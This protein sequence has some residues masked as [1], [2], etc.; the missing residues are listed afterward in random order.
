MKI[1]GGGETAE[2]QPAGK[3]AEAAVPQAGD[4]TD[5]ATDRRENRPPDTRFADVAGLDE[6]KEAV[7][8]RVILPHRYP[9]VYKRFDKKPGGGVLL[10]GPPGTGKTMIARATAGEAG[11]AFF[12][13]SCSDILSKWFGEAE[14]NVRALFDKAAGAAAAV[15]FFDEFEAL[16]TTRDGADSAM[17]R[18]I[19]E[20][21]A[22]MDGFG[23]RNNTLL[24]MAATN[25][26]W[27]IDTAFLRPGR[28]GEKIYVPL[29]DE[30][31]R[32][33]MLGRNL[34]HLPLDGVDLRDLARRTEGYSGADIKEVCERSKQPA[35][36]R[37]IESGRTEYTAITRADVEAA[38]GTVAP[39]VSA[40]ETARMER[41]R[42]EYDSAR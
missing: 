39:S 41:F 1:A 40:D 27:L 21:L 20:L 42:A 25:K 17:Q 11:A 34:G 23:T 18:L 6:V 12:P 14:K 16:G 2:R 3:S 26:P 33:Y 4:E 22:Q 38:L 5:G 37:A 8:N 19:P 9:D 24:L 36:L 30:A 15:I 31:A 35:I 13:V 29:P 28:F 10:Y 32:L 7:Y